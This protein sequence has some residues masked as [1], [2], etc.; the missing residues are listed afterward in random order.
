MTSYEAVDLVRYN[1]L[2]ITCLEMFQRISFRPNSIQSAN[3]V[4]VIEELADMLA[5]YA[6]A[7]PNVVS[8]AGTSGALALNTLLAY[9][10]DF[11]PNDE[12][13]KFSHVPKVCI[14]YLYIRYCR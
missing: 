2:V 8:N 3:Q 7:L 13:R 11:L 6:T 9:Q 4:D 10:R 1:R 5:K 14:L 12:A